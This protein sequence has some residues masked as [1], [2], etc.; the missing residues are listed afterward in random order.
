MVTSR[1]PEPGREKGMKCDCCGEIVNYYYECY[2][3]PNNFYLCYPDKKKGK[4]CHNPDHVMDDAPENPVFLNVA[5]SEAAIEGYVKKEIGKEANA[6]H[7]VSAR[8]ELKIKR[9][10]VSALGLLRQDD[11]GLEARVIESICIMANDK[12][13]LAKLYVESLK[14]IKTRAGIE[15]ALNHLP[16]GYADT[17]E[18]TMIRIQQRRG[19]DFELTVAIISWVVW[20]LRPLT[21]DELLH[22]LATNVSSGFDPEEL[23]YEDLILEATSGLVRVSDNTVYLAHYTAYEYFMA[24]GGKWFGFHVPSNLA[25]ICLSY[26]A[27]ED[28]RQPLDIRSPQDDYDARIKQ[29]PFASYAYE[30]W[31]NHAREAI[32]MKPVFTRILDFLNDEQDVAAF[33]QAF[34]YLQSA[35]ATRWEIRKGASALHI[36]AWFG[37]TD[38]IPDLIQKGLDVNYKDPA[39]KQTPLMIA[40]RQG[41][42]ETLEFLLEHRALINE[43]STDGMTAMLEAFTGKH[44]DAVEAL[45]KRKELDINYHFIWRRR[46][47]ILMGAAAIKDVQY[48]DVILLH[49]SLEVEIN[50]M[51]E[52]GVSALGLACAS[53][54][55]QVVY[56]LLKH[57]LIDVNIRDRLGRTPL[58]LTAISLK[59]TE[60]PEIA[61]LLLGNGADAEARDY[62]G[63]L[64]AIIRAAEEGNFELIEALY[65]HDN[66]LLKQTDDD[67][68]SLLHA[69]ANTDRVAIVR[70]VISNGVDVNIRDSQGRTPLHA[71]ARSGCRETIELL[72]ELGAV[73]QN[74]VSGRKPWL[75]AWQNG[76]LAAAHLLNIEIA[77]TEGPE[78]PNSPHLDLSDLPLWSLVMHDCEDLITKLAHDS[79]SSFQTA[80]ADPDTGDTALHLAMEDKHSHILP[81]LL[82]TSISLTQP[83]L[84]G[85]TPLHAAAR[86]INKDLITSLL[87]YLPHD[88][89]HLNPRDR[90][91]QTPLDLANDE[92]NVHSASLLVG[93][94]AIIE[95]KSMILPIFFRAIEYGYIDA[96]RVLIAE[97][98]APV[99]AKNSKGESAMAVAKMN[100]WRNIEREL[101]RARSLYVGVGRTAVEAGEG[102]GEDEDDDEEE[103]EAELERNAMRE[104]GNESWKVSF[105]RPLGLEDEV[106]EGERDGV[107]LTGAGERER[108]REGVLVHA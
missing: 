86:A 84:I 49:K 60:S 93:A 23:S 99:N 32:Q 22:A 61:E 9:V 4:T 64:T 103:V 53:G 13:L 36:A 10:G 101:E 77:A 80:A 81:L 12:F 96:V 75:V 27:T 14:T 71:A 70:F 48:T 85:R 94:G 69:A 55:K 90:N 44:L 88:S 3:C 6:G 42:V 108:K 5:P 104:E 47:T 65:S 83:N 1:D 58:S 15:R 20:A 39:S 38:V 102:E 56:S 107:A 97:Y 62:E 43:V 30:Y 78:N 51:D 29:Y 34:W 63:G 37:L 59:P 7:T 82:R 52:D 74:D 25:L 68:R 11:P 105:P 18:Q 106:N 98:G 72:L 35:A 92:R 95:H 2:E 66:Q 8:N 79:P 67:G 17:Y 16:E 89:T 31:G 45:L 41:H 24:E 100:G 57:P 91:Q 54:Q 19:G 40:T 46:R 50:A 26:M 28:L 21:V 87:A 33:V 76:H 73:S